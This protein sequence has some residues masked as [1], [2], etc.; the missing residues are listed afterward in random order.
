M[1][2]QILATENYL[3]GRSGQFL[4]A[5]GAVEVVGV[6]DFATEPQRVTVW[7]VG[8]RRRR[9]G[10]GSL[11]YYRVTLLAHVLALSC[12]LYLGKGKVQYRTWQCI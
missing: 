5:T 12:S 9:E 4:L 6:V 1:F 8:G 7:C 11:T 3:S 2:R 10:G